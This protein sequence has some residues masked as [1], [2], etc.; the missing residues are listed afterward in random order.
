MNPIRIVPRY[1]YMYINKCIFIDYL[2]E[3]KIVRVIFV[4]MNIL[5]VNDT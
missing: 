5:D 4:D 2:K 1:I 3:I